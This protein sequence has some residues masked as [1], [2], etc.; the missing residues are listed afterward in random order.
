MIKNN[1]LCNKTKMIICYQIMNMITNNQYIIFY[2]KFNFKIKRKQKNFKKRQNNKELTN[3]KL[4][5][6]K[7]I[8]YKF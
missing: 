5:M 7:V 2:N 1:N 6:K 8:F 3:Y 4:K